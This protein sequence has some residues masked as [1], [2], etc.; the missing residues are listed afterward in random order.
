MGHC[1]GGYFQACY[2]NHCRIYSLTVA[3]QRVATLE[4][5]Y[6]GTSWIQGQLYGPGN[7]KIID[8][9]V[10][11]LARRVVAACNKAPALDA[12][13]NTVTPLKA[14]EPKPNQRLGVLMVDEAEELIPF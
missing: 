1:V 3:G 5:A 10:I 11:Q 4:V 8:K 2:D 9:Q 7:R 14:R 13:L 12:S 6:R